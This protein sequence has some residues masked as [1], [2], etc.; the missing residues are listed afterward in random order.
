VPVRV[1]GA[2]VTAAG[3]AVLLGAFAQFAFEAGVP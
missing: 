2:V 1:A 3:A